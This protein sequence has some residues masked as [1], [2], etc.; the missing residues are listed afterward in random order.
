MGPPVNTTRAV[1][2]GVPVE[3]ETVIVS[4]ATV[5]LERAGIRAGGAAAGA[6]GYGSRLDVGADPGKVETEVFKF[7]VADLGK[8][9]HGFERWK[10]GKVERWKGSALQLTREDRTGSLA[11]RV[12]LEHGQRRSGSHHHTAINFALIRCKIG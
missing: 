1:G 9:G 12:T 10:G 2:N 4:V 3:V 6:H 11:Q 7:D 5:R 8:A